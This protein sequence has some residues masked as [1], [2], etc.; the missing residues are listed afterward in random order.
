MATTVLAVSRKRKGAKKSLA[1]FDNDRGLKFGKSNNNQ[2]TQFRENNFWGVHNHTSRGPK[3]K[4]FVQKITPKKDL[5]GA[6]DGR[7]I[8]S[9]CKDVKVMHF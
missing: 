2:G 1:H 4:A 8:Q 7:R 9:H 3:N 6:K 5:L